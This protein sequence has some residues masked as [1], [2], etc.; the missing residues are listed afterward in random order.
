MRWERR[1]KVRG[2]THG[3][4]MG[5]GRKAHRQGRRQLK[6]SHGAP[7]KGSFLEIR[8]VSRGAGGRSVR[9]QTKTECWEDGEEHLGDLGASAFCR[10]AGRARLQGGAKTRLSGQEVEAVGVNHALEELG[11]EMKEIR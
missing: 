3:T 5:E 6:D 11:S 10:V 9:C 4:K 1:G 8:S 2:D 7:E